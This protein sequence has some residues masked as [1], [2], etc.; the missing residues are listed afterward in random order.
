MPEIVVRFSERLIDVHLADPN[1]VLPEL[2]TDSVATVP[3]E[4]GSQHDAAGQLESLSAALDELR[5]QLAARTSPTDEAATTGEPTDS[6]GQTDPRDFPR[7]ASEAN[8]QDD[9]SL[10]DAEPGDAS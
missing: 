2:S 8:D 5:H 6:E 3:P 7:P 4:P 9:I 1:D 10:L